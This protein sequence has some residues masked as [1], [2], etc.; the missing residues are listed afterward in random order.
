[1]T[2]PLW[3][4]PVVSALLSAGVLAWLLGA[5]RE[6]MAVD[7]PNE[8]SLHTRPVPRSGGLAVMAGILSALLLSELPERWVLLP[9]LAVLVGISLLDDFRNL[10]AFL[11]FAIHG[12]VAATFAFLLLPERLGWPVAVFAVPVIVWMTNLFN[13]MDGSDGLA[14]GMAA[15][16]FATL[17][18][19]ATIAGDAV[20]A[21]FCLAI[22]AASLVFLRANW[23]P[24]RIFMGDGGSVP[25]GFAAAALGLIGVS[26][27]IWPAWLPVLAFS[28][29]I[30]DATVTL[31]HR[32]LR[33]EKVWQAHRTHYYQ[34]MVR[35]GL[36]HARTAKLCYVAMAGSGFSAL[37]GMVLFP[38][39]GGGLLACWLVIYAVA[40]RQIDLQWQRFAAKNPE[41][42]R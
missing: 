32:G 21:A 17:A 16:G 20:M 35:L 36:G 37:L 28:M 26:R 13:F 23:H 5:G 2:L 34:R 11:R 42:A 29:F 1:M 40:A 41:S 12:L 30:V 31:A 18:A 38:R 7:L 4:L 15:I 22:V 10:S 19:A 39:F 33:G 8:R 3:L 6:R 9:A 14:G 27:G 24:A 25:L